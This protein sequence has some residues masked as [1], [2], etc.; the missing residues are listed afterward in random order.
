M[1]DTETLTTHYKCSGKVFIRFIDP[2]GSLSH[3]VAMALQ[4][5][6]TGSLLVSDEM[7]YFGVGK[8]N[9]NK[10]RKLEV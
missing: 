5:H 4:Q 10:N 8:G 2:G 7:G 1:V 6:R 9:N 3:T